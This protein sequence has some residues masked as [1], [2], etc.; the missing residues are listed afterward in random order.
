[1]RDLNF[2][3]RELAKTRSNDLRHLVYHEM[4]DT[5]L[6]RIVNPDSADHGLPDCKPTPI[7]E[8]HITIAKPRRRGELVYAETKS[9]ISKLASEPS[10]VGELL[11][12][13]VEPFKIDWSWQKVV[14][15]LVRVAAAVLFAVAPRRF[16][17]P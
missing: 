4:V 11:S 17:P 10:A 2:G 14:P 9:F 5:L 1:L 8:D 6:G 12:Y 3:Y 15:K 16:S 7:R 13:P